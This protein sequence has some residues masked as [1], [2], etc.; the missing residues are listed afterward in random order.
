M[1]AQKK[2]QL[3]DIGDVSKDPDFPQKPRARLSQASA[4]AH[5]HPSPARRMQNELAGKLVAPLC[6]APTAEDARWSPRW[7]AA[8]LLLSCG[9]FWTAVIYGISLLF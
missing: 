9:T 3:R 7:T 1:A 5:A 6:V 8:F 2:T 4:D